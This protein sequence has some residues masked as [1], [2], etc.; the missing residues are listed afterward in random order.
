MMPLPLPNCHLPLPLLPLIHHL[1]LPLL[2]CP[3]PLPLLT[4]IHHL[5]PLMLRKTRRPALRTY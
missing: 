3:L 5:L 4:L 1:P 2:N